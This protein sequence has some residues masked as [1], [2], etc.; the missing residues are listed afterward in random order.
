MYSLSG[1]AVMVLYLGLYL[2][3]ILPIPLVLLL[4]ADVQVCTALEWSDTKRKGGKKQRQ[5]D[6]HSPFFVM[7]HVMLK[8]NPRVLLVRDLGL[9]E[10][11]GKCDLYI[12]ICWAQGLW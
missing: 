3:F 12:P 7:R 4:L 2:W 9:N 5:R 11:N 10:D 8:P 6:R 1:L